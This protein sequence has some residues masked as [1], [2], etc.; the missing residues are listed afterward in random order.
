M[1]S[2]IQDYRGKL[3]L[4]LARENEYENIASM[5]ED[6]YGC[7]EFYNLKQPFRKTS[8]FS[9]PFILLLVL[10]IST[11]LLNCIFVVYHIS[12]P[13]N[14]IYIVMTLL[15]VLFL[16]L[17]ACSDPGRLKNKYPNPK[18]F[19]DVMVQNDADRICFECEVPHSLA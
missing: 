16:V 7:A 5:I 4:D 8:R 6:N 2:A 18:N 10:L 14:M 19:F 11:F 15:P 13:L 17:S 12:L 9:G 3:P 1:T